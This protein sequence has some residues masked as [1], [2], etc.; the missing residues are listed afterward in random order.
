MHT[1][2]HSQHGGRLYAPLCPVCIPVP[3]TSMWT[4]ALVTDTLWCI[5]PPQPRWMY[6][7]FGQ[8]PLYLGTSFYMC[9]CLLRT[10]PIITPI[11]V[12]PPIHLL[13]PVDICFH[14]SQA[15]CEPHH[16]LIHKQAHLS[17]LHVKKLGLT[18]WFLSFQRQAWECGRKQDNG[19]SKW[20]QGA[21]WRQ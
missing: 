21:T 11:L 20:R 17:H 16:Q 4:A 15:T 19:D 3:F 5:V 12:T 18:P 8:D 13:L 2:S 10:M 7:T 6:L 1:C 9:H 14:L